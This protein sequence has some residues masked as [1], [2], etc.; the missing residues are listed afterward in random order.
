[1]KSAPPRPDEAVTIVARRRVRAGRERDYERWLERLVHDASRMAG[2]LGANVMRPPADAADPAAREYVSIFRFDSVA[3]LHAFE[4]SDLRRRALAE[5]ATLSEADATWERLTGLELWFS[6]PPGVLM[7][8]PS[9]FRMALV[10]TLVVYA[11]VLTIG[12]LVGLALAGAPSPLR[13]LV[14]IVIEV[15]LMTYVVMPP[16][17]RRLARFIYP[18]RLTER[19][20]GHTWPSG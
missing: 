2:F 16:L 13:L 3:T 17:T 19:G 15:F 20:P 12:S 6:A 18:A 9:R 10:L 8:Q 1:M 14:T 5:V 7:P 11:L 4:H